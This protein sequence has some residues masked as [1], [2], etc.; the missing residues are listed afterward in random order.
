MWWP[1]SSERTFKTG[2]GPEHRFLGTWTRRLASGEEQC[3][4]VYWSKDYLTAK[5]GEEEHEYMAS[6]WVL[7]ILEYIRRKRTDREGDNLLALCIEL[8]PHY[9]IT[10]AGV[11]A[12]EYL[13]EEE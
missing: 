2:F 10:V 7:L 4:D 1:K 11:A 13:E 5:Y 9:N 12:P 3:C 8:E 6:P